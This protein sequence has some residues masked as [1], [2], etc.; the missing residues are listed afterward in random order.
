MKSPFDAKDYKHFIK[1]RLA[2]PIPSLIKQSELARA[3]GCKASYLSLCLN[4]K[5]H[6]LPEQAHAIG[7]FLRLDPDELQ[8]FLLL[9]EFERSGSQ[10][11]RAY[12]KQRLKEL[13]DTRARIST[14]LKV[15][16]HEHGS[17]SDME[18]YYRDWYLVAAHM[19]VTLGGIRGPDQVAAKLGL[20]I[21]QAKQAIDTLIKIGLL[22]FRS[23]ELRATN[24]HLHVSDGDPLVAKHHANWRMV[25]GLRSHPAPATDMHYTSVYSLSEQDAEYLRDVLTQTLFKIRE[26]VKPSPEECVVAFS[27]DWFRLA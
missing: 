8:F 23:G 4:G 17:R 19:L 24:R 5:V 18:I 13:K 15:E 9:L 27:L 12:L 20:T 7:T 26:R 11:H 22:E 25:A 2:S 3:A 1:A 6:L 14:K 10:G 16:A 21:A